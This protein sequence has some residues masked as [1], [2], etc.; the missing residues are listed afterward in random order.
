VPSIGIV[1]VGGQ[2]APVE[3]GLSPMDVLRRADAAMYTAKRNKH[4]G[5]VLAD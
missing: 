3:P 2:A 5:P 4:G 1:V